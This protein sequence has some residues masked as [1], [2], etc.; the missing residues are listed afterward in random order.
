[1]NVSPIDEDVLSFINVHTLRS[2]KID[3]L[4]V[5]YFLAELF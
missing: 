1:M 2:T 5:V 3:H 4:S